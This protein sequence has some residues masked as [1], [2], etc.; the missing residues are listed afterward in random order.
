MSTTKYNGLC[1]TC[2]HRE[3]CMYAKNPERCAVHCEEF[4]AESAFVPKKHKV[5]PNPVRDRVYHKDAP[6]GLCVNCNK[7]PEC[8]FR[9]PECGVWFCEEYE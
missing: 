9:K 2:K 5:A 8:K 6:L 3:T 7:F 4:E 1:I